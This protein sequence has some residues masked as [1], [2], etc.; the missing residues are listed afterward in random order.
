VKDAPGWGCQLHL[1]E[2]AK[3]VSQ[4][5]ASGRTDYEITAS[6]LLSAKYYAKYAQLSSGAEWLYRRWSRRPA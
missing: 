5:G 1:I 4:P 6:W 3:V 2:P